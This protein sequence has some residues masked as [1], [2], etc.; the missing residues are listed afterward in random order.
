MLFEW[1]E[2]KA[3]TNFIKH[4]VSFEEAKSAFGDELGRRTRDEKHSDNED[5]FVLIGLSSHLGLLVVATAIR[6]I[7]T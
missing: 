6:S 7:Q 1:D 3:M 2:S 4:R 5:R